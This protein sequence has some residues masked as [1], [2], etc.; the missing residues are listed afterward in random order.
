MARALPVSQALSEDRATPPI[1]AYVPGT[2][3]C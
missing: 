3:W 1:P 2:Q